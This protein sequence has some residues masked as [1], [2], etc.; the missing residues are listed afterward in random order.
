LGH[1]EILGIK[2]PPRDCSFGTIHTTS[3]RPFAP[4]WFDWI[5]FAG[6]A[7]KEAA[8]GIV[9]GAEYSWDVF[10]DDNGR[11]K[12]ICSAALVVFIGDLTK[13]KGKVAARIVERIA[14]AGDGECLARR[15]A[16][17]HINGLHEAVAD[18]AGDLGHIAQVRHVR[19]VMRQ[20][21]ACESI[22]LG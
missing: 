19:I 3:V 5:I 8:E 20:H 14:Q 18:C 17:E 13:Y 15:A 9:F 7:S 12:S 21:G 16:A 22:N 11:K 2:D 4:W 1:A 6:K 10:P